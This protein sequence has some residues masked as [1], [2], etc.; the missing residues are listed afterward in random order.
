MSALRGLRLHIYNSKVAISC[1]VEKRHV[2]DRGTDEL[3]V[4]K[5]DPGR[6]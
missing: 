4:F 6:R 5:N 3:G 1:R 2:R